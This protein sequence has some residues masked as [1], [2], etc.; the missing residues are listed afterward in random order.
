MGTNFPNFTNDFTE[1]L[2]DEGFRLVAFCS[3]VTNTYFYQKK[4]VLFVSFEIFVINNLS[5]GFRKDLN[6]CNITHLGNRLSY[7]DL[8]GLFSATIT[9]AGGQ[10]LVDRGQICFRTGDDGICIGTVPAKS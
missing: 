1:K 10:E 4:F 2:P 6:D 9:T 5:I 8:G 7:G 3:R